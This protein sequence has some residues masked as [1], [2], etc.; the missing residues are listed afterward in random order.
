MA[1]P[2]QQTLMTAEELFELPN[3]DYK[4]ELVQGELIRM[5]PTG[6]ESTAF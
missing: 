1:V 4:Y 2:A 5:A 6:V 3:D